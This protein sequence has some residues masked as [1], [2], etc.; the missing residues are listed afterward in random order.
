MQ[1]LEG[2]KVCG[3]AEVLSPQITKKPQR[4]NPQSVTFC[5]GTQI[6]K[7]FEDFAICGPLTFCLYNE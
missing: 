5:E 2:E 7:L 6:N 4:A 1:Y 3:L